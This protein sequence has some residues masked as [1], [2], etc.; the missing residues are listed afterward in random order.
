MLVSV[1]RRAAGQSGSRAAVVVV[2]GPVSGGG[3][4]SC[5]S[6]S[7]G[8]SSSSSSSRRSMVLK[9]LARSACSKLKSRSHREVQTVKSHETR[10]FAAC[11]YF[12]LREWAS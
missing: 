6:S 3:S 5:S 9:D 11:S 1:S 10:R 2:S 8:S 7:S 4:S 12:L